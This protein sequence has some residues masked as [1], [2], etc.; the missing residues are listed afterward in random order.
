MWFWFIYILTMDSII[1]TLFVCIWLF[2]IIFACKKDCLEL[3]LLYPVKHKIIRAPIH[4]C[5]FTFIY[6]T[7]HNGWRLLLSRNLH[8]CLHNVQL[9]RNFCL[10]YEEFHRRWKAILC[11]TKLLLNVMLRFIKLFKKWMNFFLLLSHTSRSP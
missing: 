6:I 3:N 8:W 10:S 7:V 2:S 5:N 1:R 9:R 4:S 11:M